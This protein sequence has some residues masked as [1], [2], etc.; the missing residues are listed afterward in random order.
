MND[1]NSGSCGNERGWF[2]SSRSQDSDECVE[3]KMSNG[4]VA[5]RDSKNPDGPVL[6]EVTEWSSLVI[7]IKRGDLDLS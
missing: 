6:P 2:K 3:V 5:V 1:N 4:R 7:V